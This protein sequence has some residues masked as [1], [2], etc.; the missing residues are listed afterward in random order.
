[1]NELVA[2]STPTRIAGLL[3]Y[4]GVSLREKGAV[5]DSCMT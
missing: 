5:S 4:L 3:D 2:Y 1:M